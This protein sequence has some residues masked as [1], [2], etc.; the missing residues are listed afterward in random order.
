M[1]KLVKRSGLMADS[2]ATLANLKAYLSAPQLPEYRAHTPC[3]LP[4]KG[5]RGRRSSKAFQEVIYTIPPI[6]NLA[7]LDLKK[8]E[9]MLRGLIGRTTLCRVVWHSDI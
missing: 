3:K 8:L 4:R 7:E 9:L 6:A 5:Q 1:N 2:P